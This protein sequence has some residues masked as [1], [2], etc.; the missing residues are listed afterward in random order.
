MNTEFFC[1][2]TPVASE[3]Q[4]FIERPR[5]NRL[6]EKAVHKPIVSVIAGAGYGKTQAV[7]AFARRLN[8]RTAW[9]QISER[10]NLGVRFWENFVSAVSIISKEAAGKLS[11]MDFPATD[12]QFD[13]YLAIYRQD[14][15]L[16]EKYL[17][18][19]DDVHLITTKAVLTFL[20]RCIS[21][22][23]PNITSVLIS[24]SEPQLDMAKLEQ[25]KLLARITENKIKF[26]LDE[27]LSYFRLLNVRADPGMASAIYR[28]TEGWAFAIHLAA[29]SLRN[30]KSGTSHVSLLLKYNT[31]KLI[32]SEIA[33][34]LSPELLRFLIKLSL[35]ENLNPDL[36]FEIGGNAALVKEMENIVS[37]VS[38]DAYSNSYHIHNLFL[39][40]L[41]EK[42]NKLTE[43]EKKDVW[44]KTAQWCTENNRKMDAIISYDKAGDYSG[45]VKILSTMPL[46]LP[47]GVARFI[48][49]IL[50]RAPATIYHD[51]HEALTI[52]SR[53]LNSLG[54]FLQNREETL[55]I[56]PMMQAM[57]ESTKK[58]VILTA[59]YVNLGFIGLLQSFYTK[60]Y[61]FMCYFKQALVESKEANLQIKPPMNVATLASYVCRV[62]APV[63]LHEMEK[64]IEVIGE[65]VPYTVQ[66]LG[67]CQAGLH[68]LCLGE[69]AFFRGEV[70]KAEK[71]LIESLARARKNDQYEIENR[72]LFYLLRV[73]MSLDEADKIENI[74]KQLENEL[75]QPLYLNRY[76]YYDI[77]S[78]WYYIQTGRKEKVATWL[79]NDHENSDLNSR[80]QGLEKLV[81]AK[82]YFS[83]KRYPAAL[84]VME[85]LG[86]SEPLL[87]GEIEMKALE[88]V[89]R[90][91]LL[92][93]D[94]ALKALVQAY[95]LAAPTEL[96][97][98]FVELGKDMRSLT[99][100]ALRDISSGSTAAGIC[101][102]WLQETYRKSAAYAKK[103]FRQSKSTRASA[104]P[105]S[106]REMSVLA[107]LSHGL[108]QEEI[109]SSASISPNTV[110]SAI[111]S[112][113]S[114]FGALNKADAVR[115]AAERGILNNAR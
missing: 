81:K 94:G 30:V 87:F 92:D 52:R 98:P 47:T 43:E 112:I 6:L 89:C 106:P 71:F 2:H 16:N 66:V 84:A 63:S 67:G 114:K 65:I 23:L 19:F 9:I 85:S 73:Y 79:K 104:A 21:S 14:V 74:V 44:I 45:I 18:V 36:V 39:D 103:I 11:Q 20:E 1:G 115:I 50:E 33:S 27:L 8:V 90:C 17:F 22:F 35:V 3:S 31:S 100:T 40:Y 7:Y 13:R 64:Y 102:Q 25:K 80:V 107:G 46:I 69:F 48:L 60:Q 78:G 32:E 24:R 109:A 91:R 68:E 76:F 55:K 4:I 72:A 96:F 58:H 88:A 51:Y 57:P 83:E 5:I 37:F 70:Q 29:L 110:K 105:L 41:H 113:Y 34:S 12:P 28:D 49:D 26:S 93:K 62:M 86:E 111:R 95:Q 53:A 99:Q 38:F 82:Y 42:Q 10:D 54:C 56:I 101:P 59:C 77:V 75:Q 108:T 61:N 97:M 15:I